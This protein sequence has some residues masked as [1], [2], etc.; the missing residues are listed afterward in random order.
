MT[1]K[2]LKEEIKR[3]TSRTIQPEDLELPHKGKDGWLEVAAN[4]L[5]IIQKLAA[6]LK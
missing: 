3:L 1:T 5:L 4:R 2:D 6:R